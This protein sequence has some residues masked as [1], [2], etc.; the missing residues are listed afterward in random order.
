MKKI[1]GIILI[2]SLLLA[3]CGSEEVKTSTTKSAT[4][5]TAVSAEA[6]EEEKGAIE[7]TFSN[8]KDAMAAAVPMKC[9]WSFSDQGTTMDGVTTVSGKKFNSEVSF[10]GNGQSFTSNTVSDGTY[11]YF[12][13]DMPGG[14]AMKMT[15]PDDQATSAPSEGSAQMMD[16]EA[17]YNYK[18]A[19]TVTSPGTFN[20]PNMEF[21][22]MDAMMAD[23]GGVGQSGD[24]NADMEALAAKYNIE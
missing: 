7:S 15:I 6:G 11:M 23:M 12:W 10:E 20:P 14:R 1:I 21:M 8:L 3:G 16:L 22:D 2:L 5:D 9:T 19:P 13:S 18:C 17:N 4:S 24:P